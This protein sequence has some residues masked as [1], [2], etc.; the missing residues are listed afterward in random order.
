MKR[1]AS[2]VISVTE[3]DNI[4][5]D[6]IESGV[7]S[8]PLEPPPPPPPPPGLRACIVPN[9]TSSDLDVSIQENFQELSFSSSHDE[10]LT[11]NENLIDFD[12]N[13]EPPTP[14]SITSPTFNDLSSSPLMPQ[15]DKEQVGSVT[16][17][18]EHAE[19]NDES[20]G[21]LFQS[22]CF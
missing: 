14:L 16:H 10:V 4:R 21:K 5:V 6:V 9:H 2:C 7:R 17:V 15:K 18:P 12:T 8:N 13:S 20:N 19:Q 3:R 1:I 11:R 22:T